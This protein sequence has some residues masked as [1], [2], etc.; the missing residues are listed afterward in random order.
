MRLKFKH[1]QDIDWDLIYKKLHLYAKT[2][3]RAASIVIDGLSAQDVVGEALQEF[4]D[5]P[6]KLGWNA[7]KGGLEPFLKAVV[8]QR[9]IDHIRPLKKILADSEKIPDRPSGDPSPQEEAIVEEL[10]W[11]LL[12]RIEGRED[13][14]EL[15]ELV[16]AA[17]QITAKGPVNQDLAALLG[18]TPQEVVNRRK[19]LL[20]ILGGSP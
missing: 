17:P 12:E 4:F 3:F 2:L 7:T 13:E 18:V 16:V 20:R 19:R 11:G 8:R 6:N 9:F 10:Q 15:E 1:Y 14:K 5:S